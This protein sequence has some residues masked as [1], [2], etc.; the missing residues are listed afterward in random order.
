MNLN[1]EAL[2]A[3]EK[4][5]LFDLATKFNM[6]VGPGSNKRDNKAANKNI[7]QEHMEKESMRSSESKIS[8]ITNGNKS[9]GCPHC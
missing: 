6:Y 5:Q 9:G 4:Q 8:R 7:Q 1:P 2:E 3:Q